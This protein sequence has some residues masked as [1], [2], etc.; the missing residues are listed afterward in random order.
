MTAVGASLLRSACAKDLLGVL[1]VG[2]S[3]V[4]DAPSVD[5]RLG[6]GEGDGEGVCCSMGLGGVGGGVASFSSIGCNSPRDEKPGRLSCP[7]F[8]TGVGR[9]FDIRHDVGGEGERGTFVSI[10][11][12]I[13]CWGGS[14]GSGR[15]PREGGDAIEACRRALE[16]AGG[17]GDV[18]GLVGRDT[19]SEGNLRIVLLAGALFNASTDSAS[20]GRAAVSIVKP[21]PGLF[22]GVVSIGTGGTS[23]SPEFIRSSS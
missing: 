14:E 17:D 4:E 2:V 21:R 7:I 10:V 18:D 20:C 23:H 19:G 15:F 8:S 12:K 6:E 9:G 11:G 22:F 1:G 13:F 16:V 3:L 5:F